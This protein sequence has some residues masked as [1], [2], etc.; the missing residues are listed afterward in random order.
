MNNADFIKCTELRDELNAIML[1]DEAER[2]EPDYYIDELLFFKNGASIITIRIFPDS[3]ITAD[4]LAAN[5]LHDTN[6]NMFDRIELFHIA[7]F[8]DGTYDWKKPHTNTL[9]YIQ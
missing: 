4:T 5:L 7:I 8:C 6:Y 3:T 1:A 9:L 2:N